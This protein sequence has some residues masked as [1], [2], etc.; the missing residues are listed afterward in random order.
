MHNLPK[1]VQCSGWEDEQRKV[2]DGKPVEEDEAAADAATEE[3]EEE[4]EVYRRQEQSE[5]AREEEEA[6]V[7]RDAGV[8]EEGEGGVEEGSVEGEGQTPPV[9]E[10]DESK[11]LTS[12]QVRASVHDKE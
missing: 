9:E 7:E 4:G 3:E 5:E 2:E 12:Q 8:E 6:A 10:P 1:T 11:E